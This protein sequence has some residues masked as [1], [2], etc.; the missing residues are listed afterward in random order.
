MKKLTLCA[1]S[2]TL[3]LG[4]NAYAQNSNQ[5]SLGWGT[6]SDVNQSNSNMNNN[7]NRRDRS[8]DRNY[9]NSGKQYDERYYRY[10]RNYDKQYRNHYNKYHGY[11]GDEPQ[12]WDGVGVPAYIPPGD[13]PKW[14]D[15]SRP[16]YTEDGKYRT[17]GKPYN[18]HK[19]S[20]KNQ[21][22]ATTSGTQNHTNINDKSNENN[23]SYKSNEQ[24]E[25][26]SVDKKNQSDEQAIKNETK[27]QQLGVQ[28]PNMVK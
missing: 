28:Q 21:N 26:N 25:N 14:Y 20:G 6:Y 3:L 22:K 2:A 1:L 9:N 23:R 7:D 18:Y 19:K 27:D 5:D 17:D 11:H 24:R 4:A 8:Y 16:T 15:H 12:G 13:N 10:Y